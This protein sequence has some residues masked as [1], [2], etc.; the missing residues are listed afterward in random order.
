VEIDWKNDCF[1]F[2]TVLLNGWELSQLWRYVQVVRA[3]QTYIIRVYL[4]LPKT[5]HLHNISVLINDEGHI[6]HLTLLVTWV[7]LILIC[8]ELCTEFNTTAEWIIREEPIFADHL[9]V[10]ECWTRAN[11]V[12]LLE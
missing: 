9:N 8:D 10:V 11:V 6:C 4:Y 1:L 12:I 2:I 7:V 3:T 5:T